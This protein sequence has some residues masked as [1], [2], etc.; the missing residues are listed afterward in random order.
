M[1]TPTLFVEGLWN[2]A[3]KYRF[4]SH[5]IPFRFNSQI[6]CHPHLTYVQQKDFGSMAG[7]KLR[8][9]ILDEQTSWHP[10]CCTPYTTWEMFGRFKNRA[11]QK[12]SAKLPVPIPFSQTRHG[13]LSSLCLPRKNDIVRGRWP[14][15]HSISFVSQDG[16]STLLLQPCFES[17]T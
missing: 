4:W 14:P 1:L 17:S 5:K 6:K 7:W 12:S 16:L 2:L 10:G 15:L 8:R 9:G 11:R 3:K 13:E